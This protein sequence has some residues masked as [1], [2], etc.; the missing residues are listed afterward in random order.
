MPQFK[1]VVCA[2]HIN[3]LEIVLH[4]LISECGRRLKRT[5]LCLLVADPDHLDKQ[6]LQYKS[7]SPDWVDKRQINT[8]VGLFAGLTPLPLAQTDASY[9]QSNAVIKIS[10]LSYCIHTFIASNRIQPISDPL[11]LLQQV[12][13][14]IIELSDYGFAYAP[15]LLIS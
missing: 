5:N 4:V 2:C 1:S 15:D 12:I 11:F 9:T 8:D 10:S 3:L 14:L 13:H 7:S 6:D